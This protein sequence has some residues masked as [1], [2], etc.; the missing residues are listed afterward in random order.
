M[1]LTTATNK[2]IQAT[3]IT[4]MA[5]MNLFEA[6]LDR[7]LQRDHEATTRSLKDIVEMRMSELEAR[8]TREES[9]TI[10]GIIY[11]LRS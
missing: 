7:Q 10:A 2:K 9:Q 4:L 1:D 3:K 5:E 6:G 11:F 8:L